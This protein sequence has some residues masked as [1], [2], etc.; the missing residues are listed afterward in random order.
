MHAV[1]SVVEI[2]CSLRGTGSLHV[3]YNL[4][5]ISPSALGGIFSLVLLIVQPR[6]LLQLWP[7]TCLFK[8]FHHYKVVIMLASHPFDPVLDINR[9]EHTNVLDTDRVELVYVISMTIILSH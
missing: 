8:N 4:P 7:E 1:A 6:H 2:A 5:E 3:M 9:C